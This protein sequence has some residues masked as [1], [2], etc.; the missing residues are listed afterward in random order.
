MLGVERGKNANF[1][2]LMSIPVILG[3]A[4]LEGYEFAKAPSVDIGALPLLL[5]VLAAAVIVGVTAL[6]VWLQRRSKMRV[7]VKRADE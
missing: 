5:G 1:A 2:F 7:I 4:L 3:S 6:V